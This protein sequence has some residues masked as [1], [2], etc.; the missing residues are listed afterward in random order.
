VGAKGK[1]RSC[2]L[3]ITYT[4]TVF[5]DSSL[6]PGSFGAPGFFGL[7][8]VACIRI[9][10]RSLH[11]EVV[12]VP[13]KTIYIREADTELWEKAEV[14][15]GGSVSALLTEALRR[16]VEEEEQRERTGMESIEVELWGPEERPYKA[17]FVGRWLLFPDEMETRTGEP[18]YDAGA[19]YG[20]ALTRRGDIA[21][22]TRHVNDGFAPSLNTYGSFEKA[23]E[24]EVPGDILAMAASEIS[25]G[26]VQKLD[27]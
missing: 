17:T 25:D 18:G 27:I 4:S 7:D 22:Y 24:A 1:G 3:P 11:E 16:Y 15:A 23:E 12:V 21:V 9:L 14:L 5:P 6:W 19:Y 13:N 8:K 20:V 26:Y 2:V 10:I